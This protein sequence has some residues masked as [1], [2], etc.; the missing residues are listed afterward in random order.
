MCFASSCQWSSVVLERSICKFPADWRYQDSASLAA[1]AG[2][3]AINDGTYGGDKVAVARSHTNVPVPWF[4][5]EGVEAVR[6]SSCQGLSRMNT[7][8]CICMYLTETLECYR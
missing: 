4:E 7:A 5:V 2:N 3:V 8:D 1:A 6:T